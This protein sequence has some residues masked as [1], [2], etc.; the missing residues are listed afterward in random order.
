MVTNGDGLL[1]SYLHTR[2]SFCQTYMHFLVYPRFLVFLISAA[3][4]CGICS[5]P[6]SPHSVLYLLETLETR[7]FL[8]FASAEQSVLTSE[9]YDPPFLYESTCGA[10]V[11]RL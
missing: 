10:D 1:R 5:L 9:V 6:L 7:T 4:D 2:A 8:D 3:L 11:L